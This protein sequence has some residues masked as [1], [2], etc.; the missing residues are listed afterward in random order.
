MTTICDVWLDI[1]SLVVG[2]IGAWGNI[3]ALA[4]VLG[5]GVSGII[6]CPDPLSIQFGSAVDNLGWRLSYPLAKN[7]LGY[8]RLFTASC[9][10]LTTWLRHPAWG[11]DSYRRHLEALREN[12]AFT[13]SG[14]RWSPE[15]MP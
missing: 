2:V 4:R 1:L 11:L 10:P 5:R 14:L 12:E 7:P 15:V 9:I 3:R 6:A 8:P 13:R